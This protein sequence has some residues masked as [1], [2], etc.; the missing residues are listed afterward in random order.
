MRLVNA[1]DAWT[2]R[3]FEERGMEDLKMYFMNMLDKTQKQM[4]C[5]MP[6]LG[7]KQKDLEEMVECD[8]Y[9]ING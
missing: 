6:K 3:A 2:I 1:L 8:F 4:L 9:I 7:Y 5:V